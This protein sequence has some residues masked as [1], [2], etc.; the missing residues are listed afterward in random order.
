MLER[1]LQLSA[2]KLTEFGSLL[3]AIPKWGPDPG[4]SS[5]RI[6]YDALGRLIQ[7]YEDPS[8]LKYLTSYSYDALD[9][10]RTATQGSQ[11][12]TCSYDMLSRLTSAATP[13][14]GTTSFYYTTSGGGLCSGGRSAVCR[15][16]DA[17]GITATYRYDALSWLGGGLDQPPVPQPVC[18]RAE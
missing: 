15:R 6:C 7:V 13:E 12:R 9:S 1:L 2:G 16:S 3:S 18:L 17:R 8:G 4:R 11:T 14:S 10:L 5:R